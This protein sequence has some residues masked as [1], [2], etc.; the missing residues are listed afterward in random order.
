M[1]GG[2]GGSAGAS[3]NLFF[4]LAWLRFRGVGGWVGGLRNAVKTR[5]AGMS[6]G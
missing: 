6:C 5:G 2:G 1:S 3:G 4:S